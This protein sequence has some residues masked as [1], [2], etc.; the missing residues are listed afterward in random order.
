MYLQIEE[1]ANQC[2]VFFDKLLVNCDRFCE[3]LDD[4]SA[5]C[6]ICAGRGLHCYAPF[7]QHFV[8]VEVL[9]SGHCS[10]DWITFVFDG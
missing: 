2:L 6:E 10:C 7:L 4:P 1:N 8:D 9:M 5:F 3:F